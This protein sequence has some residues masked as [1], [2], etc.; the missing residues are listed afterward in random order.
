MEVL[1]IDHF[2]NVILNFTK[3]DWEVLEQPEKVKI[4]LN[5]GFIYG[6][7]NTFSDAFEKQVLAV[8]DSTGHLQIAQNKG[9]AAELLQIKIGDP[10]L[11]CM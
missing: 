2:G 10:V 6:I 1:H 11:L 5:N 4:K 8:W 3:N 9:N 7:K